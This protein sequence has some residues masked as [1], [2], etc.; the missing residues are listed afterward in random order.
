MRWN[1]TVM[2]I[3]FLIL[4]SYPCCLDDIHPWPC[5]PPSILRCL[6]GPEGSARFFT[7]TLPYCIYCKCTLW[8]DSFICPYLCLCSVLLMWINLFVNLGPQKVKIYEETGGSIGFKRVVTPSKSEEENKR[9]TSGPSPKQGMRE[10]PERTSLLPSY[11][12]RGWKFWTCFLP[13]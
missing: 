6:S 5:L 7:E 4:C 10:E 9:I 11:Q 3:V 8:K 2:N 13:L 1:S 12:A